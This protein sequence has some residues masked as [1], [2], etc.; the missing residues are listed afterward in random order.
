MMRAVARTV[1]ALV[2]LLAAS[3]FSAGCTRHTT[4]TAT[5]STSASAT[6]PASI[7]SSRSGAGAATAVDAYRGMWQAY[8]EAATISDPAYGPLTRYTQGDALAVFVKGLTSIRDDGLVGQ[9]DVALHPEVTA[10]HPNTQPPTVELKDCVDTSA[11]HL[12]KR[13]GSPY[14]D[15][16]GGRRAAKAT[17]SQLA[18]GSWKVSGFALFSIGSC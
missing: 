1:P 7:P 9:G 10:A 14:Q 2:V 6:A 18:D 3:A 4:P 12:V 8:I 11:T 17:V 5:P 16:P 13:D 15:T